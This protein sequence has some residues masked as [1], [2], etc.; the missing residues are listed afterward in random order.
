[1]K[2]SL[3]QIKTSTTESLKVTMSQE[4]NQG[5]HGFLG[6]FFHQPMAGVL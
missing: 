3:D 6:A 4:A 1:M 5:I 2:A